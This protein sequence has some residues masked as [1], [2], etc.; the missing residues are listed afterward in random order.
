MAGGED[1]A[2]QVIANVVV[3][4]GFKRNFLLKREFGVLLL[5]HLR[6]A[7][8]IQRAV[9]RRRHQPGAGI[10]RYAG[11]GPGFQRRDQ[12]LLRELL[13]QA[14][15]AHHARDAGDD[16]S[17]LDAP[18]GFDGATRF[19]HRKNSTSTGASTLGFTM[20][21]WPSSV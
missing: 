20:W 2:Q 17:R 15:V 16:L 7:K 9:L 8:M 3:P 14:A 19:L 13:G 12:R 6:A 10:V 21:F 18:D 4:V 11:R 5:Q 1:Q